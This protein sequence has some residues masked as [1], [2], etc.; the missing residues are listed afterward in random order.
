MRGRDHFILYIVG[1]EQRELDIVRRFSCVVAFAARVEPC[2]ELG[3]SVSSAMFIHSWWRVGGH[4]VV[5]HCLLD[6]PIGLVCFGPI[7]S[8]ALKRLPLF[9]RR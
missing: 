8:L 4:S 7:S 2:N 5:S 1:L 6:S 3:T 9:D